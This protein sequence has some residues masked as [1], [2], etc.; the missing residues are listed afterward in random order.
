MQGFTTP[1]PRDVCRRQHAS[2]ML[3]NFRKLGVN[4]VFSMRLRRFRARRSRRSL[5]LLIDRLTQLHRLFGEGLGLGIHRLDIAAFNR[6]LGLD[7]GR[8]DLADAIAL[9]GQK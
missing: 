8:L 5:L 2:L 3:V 6:S 9:A 4:H 7:D 1:A